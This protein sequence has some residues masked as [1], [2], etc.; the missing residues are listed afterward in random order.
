LPYKYTNMAG[1]TLTSNE[2]TGQV[3]QQ[4]VYHDF[5][6]GGGNQSPQLRWENPPAGT[7]SFL[8]T[9]YD[10]DAPGP[11]WWHWCAFDIPAGTRDLSTNDSHDSMP[12]GTVQTVNSYGSQGYGG[13]CP[14]PGDTA[15][16]YHLTI[17]A[18]KTE[19][20]GLDDTAQPAMVLFVAAE[21]MIGKAGVTAFY[22][23]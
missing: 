20:L 10:P 17:Y 15:H 2:F 5:G 16:A 22:A 1:F 19:S 3:P 13:A 18:L 4:N 6:A 14:P 12:G 23:R 9:C 7:K 8:V 11:G 21:H